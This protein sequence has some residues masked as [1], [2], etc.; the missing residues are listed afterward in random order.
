MNGTAFIQKLVDSYGFTK[1]E[2]LEIFIADSKIWVKY[3]KGSWSGET[4]EQ[5]LSSIKASISIEFLNN[6]A[7]ETKKQQK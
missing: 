2:P 3:K 7:A 5:V 6:I 4:L 1:D